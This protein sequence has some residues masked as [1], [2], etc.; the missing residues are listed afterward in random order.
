MLTADDASHF[1]LGA[2]VLL[3]GETWLLVSLHSSVTV[4]GSTERR[5]R[6]LRWDIWRS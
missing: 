3:R 6:E 5:D 4:V 1:G 2:F